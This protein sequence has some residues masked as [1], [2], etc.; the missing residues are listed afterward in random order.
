MLETSGSVNSF[1]RT[2]R[3]PRAAPKDI[4]KAARS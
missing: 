2:A 4:A 1:P 3:D